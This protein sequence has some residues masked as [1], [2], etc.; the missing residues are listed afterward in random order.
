MERTLPVGPPP[1]KS[2]PADTQL[3]TSA[4]HRPFCAPQKRCEKALPPAHA[5]V[6]RLGHATISCTSHLAALRPPLEF[7]RSVQ[8]I[9][10][11]GRPALFRGCIRSAS[12]SFDAH[13]ACAMIGYVEWHFPYAF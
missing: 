6:R 8:R 7:L 5:P 4:L 3:A 12:V 11:G 2:P 10:R 9:V 13:R 1:S